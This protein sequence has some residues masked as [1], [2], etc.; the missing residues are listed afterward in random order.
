M[1]EEKHYIYEIARELGLQSKDLRATIEGWNLGWD[2]SSHMKKLSDAQVT[3]LKK[4]LEAE[5]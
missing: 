3:E 4:R 1:T 2:V 5:P